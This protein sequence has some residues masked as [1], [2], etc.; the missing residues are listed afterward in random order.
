MIANRVPAQNRAGV[1]VVNSLQQNGYVHPRISATR[2][3]CHSGI[4]CSHQGD[5]LTCQ[6]DTVG[7]AGGVANRGLGF[8]QLRLRRKPCALCPGS[9]ESCCGILFTSA[10]ARLRYRCAEG[11]TVL[12]RSALARSFPPQFPQDVIRVVLTRNREHPRCRSAH[13]LSSASADATHHQGAQPS[14]R[15]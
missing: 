7:S 12:F 5:S 4:R 1:L 11:Y 14:H 3:G 15:G 6:I 8:P 9:G 2:P 10:D 13:D